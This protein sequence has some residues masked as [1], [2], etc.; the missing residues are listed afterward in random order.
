MKT[1]MFLVCFLDGIFHRSKNYLVPK[2]RS[3]KSGINPKICQKLS[4]QK[5]N[6][7]GT[8]FH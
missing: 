5:E 2:L 1:H 4:L 7:K 3:R 8:E 6:L